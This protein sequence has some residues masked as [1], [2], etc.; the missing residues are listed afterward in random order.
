MWPAMALSRIRCADFSFECSQFVVEGGTLVQ[1][2]KG[3][4]D[5]AMAAQLIAPPVPAFLARG[6][7]FPFIHAVAAAADDWP[8]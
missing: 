2:L 5:L 8:L 6:F 7:F 4:V 1:G 3:L